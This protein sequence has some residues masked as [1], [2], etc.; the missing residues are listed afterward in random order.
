MKRKQNKP[1]KTVKPP[2]RIVVCG[3]GTLAIKVANWFLRNKDYQLLYI[4]PVI[5]EPT[6]TKSLVSWASDNRINVI[7]TGDYSDLPLFKADGET[8]DLVVSVF[9]DKIFKQE[10]ITKCKKIINIHN[11]PLPRYRGVSPI[12]WALKN[13][14]QKHGVTIHEIIDGIDQGPIISQVEFS[15]YPDFDEV[16]DVYRRSLV[17]A[18]TLFKQTMPLINRIKSVHQDEGNASYY[19]KKQNSL[20]GA[21]NGFTRKK[22]KS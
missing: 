15:I 11:A 18:W 6:W 19:S 5:P 9:Y 7:K 21:R 3:K 12:N 22:I 13:N 16:K 4:V 17:F 8:I 10:F 1:M 20:L 2:T 14:E